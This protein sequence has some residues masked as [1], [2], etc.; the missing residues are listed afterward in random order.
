MRFNKKERDHPEITED[1]IS[2]SNIKTRAIT[3]I[4]INLHFKI[5]INKGKIFP[6]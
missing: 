5:P 2:S 1:K 6:A 3:R 4:D